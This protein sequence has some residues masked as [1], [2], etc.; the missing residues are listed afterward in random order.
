M[1]YL[2]FIWGNVNSRSEIQILIC[3]IPK[4][5]QCHLLTLNVKKF[6]LYQN[7]VGLVKKG[8]AE[9][10]HFRHG[11]EGK[12]KHTHIGLMERIR[13]V[14]GHYINATLFIFLLV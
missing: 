2:T 1:I 9:E 14:V 6:F 5:V 12:K 3:L 4:S 13:V 7:V 8:F 11:L 10:K